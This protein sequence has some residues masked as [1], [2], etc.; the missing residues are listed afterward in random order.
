MLKPQACRPC[1]LFSKSNGFSKPEGTCLN[2][3][4]ILGE[5]LGHHEFI[6]AKPF[7]PQGV[8]G[9][10]LEQVFRI[11]REPR[12][13]FLIDNIVRCQPPN[14]QLHGYGYELEAIRCCTINYSDRVY[15][16]PNVR[17]ILALGAVAFRNISGLQGKKLNIS[18]LR[19]YVVNSNV[20]R[21]LP[22][23][24]SYHPAHIRRGKLAFTDYLIHD[25]R[26]ALGVANGTYRSY[27][28]SSNYSN[29]YIL[30]PSIDDAK[31]FFYRVK[32]SPTVDLA[33]DIETPN[34]S[35]LE[36]DEREEITG[37]E[38]ISIQF[39]LGKGGG[40]YFPW[41]GDYVKVAQAI[42]RR[43]NRKLCFN[44]WHFDNPKL[45]ANNTVINGVVVDLMW[46]FHH[47]KPDLELGLGKVASMCDFPFYWKYMSLDKRMERFYAVVDAEVLHYIYP[48]LEGILKNMK[49][50]Q[51]YA[52]QIYANV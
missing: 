7:R 39:S 5:A 18:D 13:N 15:S 35:E 9:S 20:K 42:L 33:Y 34:S 46:C 19:G 32:D 26:K 30:S 25:L 8:A 45:M 3:V 17:C 22:V 24:G 29:S 2:G 49:V 4:L 43:N 23:I 38:I 48:K 50:P 36:E 28:D 10:L 47:L 21:N 12:S 41:E 51:I 44:G 6:D 40:I 16:N 14:D 11:V 31:S 52:N 1:P 27:C 37:N